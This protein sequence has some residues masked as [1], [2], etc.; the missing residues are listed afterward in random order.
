MD[1]K[2][3]WVYKSGFDPNSTTARIILMKHTHAFQPT[4]IFILS[5]IKFRIF[6]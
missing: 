1:F 5:E 6:V 4:E 2:H 3:A